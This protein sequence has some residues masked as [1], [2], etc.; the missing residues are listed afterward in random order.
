MRG[1]TPEES[2]QLVMSIGT[3]RQT[4]PLSPA[5]TARLI[6]RAR[7]AGETAASIAAAAGL[8]G[9]TMIGRLS[10]ME[11][12]D[13]TVAAMVDWGDSGATLSFSSAVDLARI[14]PGDQLRVAMAAL[15]SRMTR[16]EVKEVVQL[17]ER[18]GQDAMTCVEEVVQSRPRLDTINVTLG[19]IVDAKVVDRLSILPQSERDE[20]L[21]KSLL[22]VDP[23]FETSQVRLGSDH[24][25]IATRGPAYSRLDRKSVV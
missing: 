7:A 5:E 18:S 8:T 14:S 17:I 19:E 11:T 24:F 4:R 1:L 6:S 2:A 12:L 23:I 3:Q 13:P 16:F 20:M 25:V 21:K 9:T 22:S 10:K 15:E